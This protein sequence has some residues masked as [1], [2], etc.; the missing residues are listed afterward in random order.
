LDQLQGG[1]GSRDTLANPNNAKKYEF[2]DTSS[3]DDDGELTERSEKTKV[4]DGDDQ[5]CKCGRK[6]TAAHSCQYGVG[7]EAEDREGKYQRSTQVIGSVLNVDQMASINKGKAEIRRM[8][9]EVEMARLQKRR[10]EETLYKSKKMQEE[11]P[12][13]SKPEQYADS[14]E[15]DLQRDLAQ[16]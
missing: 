16:A 4:R 5:M 1:F 9:E 10:V 15:R 12:Y 6:M 7:G 11:N 8:D 13:A 14:E 2:A 3:D